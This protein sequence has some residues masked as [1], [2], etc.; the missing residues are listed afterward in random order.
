MSVIAGKSLALWQSTGQPIAARSCEP[1]Q[2]SH[3]NARAAACASG[4]MTCSGH[5]LLNSIIA[6]PCE[7]PGTPP[8][9]RQL[10]HRRRWPPHLLPGVKLYIPVNLPPKPIP[11]FLAPPLFFRLQ[12]H[13]H[14]GL[15]RH[16]LTLFFSAHTKLLVWTGWFRPK[17]LKINIPHRQSRGVKKS[18]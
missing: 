13:A 7:V 12:A 16:V 2:P 3:P 9:Q 15:H 1:G 18:C 5:D 4:S 10:P 8:T 11:P 6:S 17:N 14:D